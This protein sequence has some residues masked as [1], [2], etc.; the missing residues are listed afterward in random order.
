MS[1][2][3]VAWV[4]LPAALAMTLSACG[5]GGGSTTSEGKEN[6][7]GTVSIYGTEPKSTLFPANTTEAGGSKVTEA[8]F[9]RLVDYAPED[10][11]PTNLL[12]ESITSS[13]AKVYNIKLKQGWKF[14]DGTDVKA[15]NF[16]DGWNWSAN[17]NNAQQGASFFSV[18]QGFKDV[19]PSDEAAKPT[20]DKMSGL[21]V[22]G[23]YEFKVTL[24]A[25]TSVFTTM[26]GYLPF[27]PLPDAFF[28]DP[29]A[30]EAKPIGN[31][32]LKF[33]SR[34]PNS[35]I[36]LERFD[37]YKGEKIHFKTLDIKIY[38]SQETAYQD[39][40]A[41]KLDFME[42][43]PPSAKVGEKYKADLGDQVLTANLLGQSAIA[44]P[45]Y[46]PAFKDNVKLRQA[47]S[48]AINREQIT[49]TVLAG[50]YTP[51][52]GWVSPGINGYRKGVC[53]EF[54]TYNKDK[55]KQLFQESG[56]TGKL[57]IQSNQDGGRKE[58]LE[59]ACNSIKDAL[60][61]ECEFV[62]AT[63]FGAFRQ[64]VD[65]KQLTGMSRSDWSADY[66]SIENF[67]NPLYRTGGSSNDSNFSNPEVDKLLEQADGTA[68]EA[69]AIKLYQQAEDIIAKQMPSIPTWNEKGIGGRS[70]NL[71]AAKLTFKRDADLASF[72]VK[73]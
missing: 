49:K 9:A 17:S 50:S 31:G 22:V 32:P 8:L 58:P 27:S 73:G 56:F 44:L 26:I 29:K 38:S 55:A 70:K 61:V 16:V 30:F 6:P 52:D 60:G 46:V 66:P 19:H 57:T 10:G 41:G 64:I 39:L 33:V 7:E 45:Y 37:D 63:N 40:V 47:I 36:K 35:L 51:S 42:A 72:R 68:D 3:R 67:L 14:H 13:D 24:N 69:A 71:L 65:G 1:R 53:G 2:S 4:A 23:D 20:A 28:A 12:A 34:T 11:K 21:E 18:I 59:A 15:K 43:L 5:G 25:P 54:C 48:M 62:G